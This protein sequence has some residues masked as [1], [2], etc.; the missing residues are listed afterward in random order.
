MKFVFKIS[1][2]VVMAALSSGCMTNNAQKGAAIGAAA[3]AVVGKSTANHST[4]RTVIGAGLGALIGAAVGNYMDQQEQEFRNELS[5][6]GVDI[7]REGDNLRLV[8][9]SNI[10]FATG[11]ANISSGFYPVLDDISTIL[12]KY[13]KTALYVEGHTDDVGSDASN[14]SL[15]NL[16][17][18]SVKDYLVRKSVNPVRVTTQGY[19][20]SRP[21]VPNTS[22]ENRAQ[23]RRVEIQIIP[24][25][26]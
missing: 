12:A 4:K 24:N 22:A 25:K 1:T 13:E 8:M 26:A 16:R 11:Q 17:A 19:G 5:G 14:L 18:Q 10:T 2:V 6:S 3:G 7:V 23:N 21:V 9:P 15:S 20:E